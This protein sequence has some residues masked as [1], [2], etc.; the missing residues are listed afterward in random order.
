MN[1]DALWGGLVF[2]L[3]LCALARDPDPREPQPA[4][5][6]PLPVRGLCLVRCPKCRRGAEAR[7]SDGAVWCRACDEAFYPR[8]VA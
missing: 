6:P 7:L 1:G 5:A 8:L 3:L 2:G 4:A